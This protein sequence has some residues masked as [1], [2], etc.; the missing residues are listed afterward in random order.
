MAKCVSACTTRAEKPS[1]GPSTHVGWLTAPV[2]KEPDTPLLS[3]ST[4]TH[5]H[6]PTHRST[7][8]LKIY[9]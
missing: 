2:Y 7:H 1:L 9:F 4:Y 8:N 5:V 6:M 3:S